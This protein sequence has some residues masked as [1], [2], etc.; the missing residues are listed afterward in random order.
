MSRFVYTFFRYTD[1]EYEKIR[2]LACKFHVIGKEKSQ[3]GNPHLQGYIEFHFPISYPAFKRML[4][5]GAHIEKA[6]KSR[7]PNTI[8]CAKGGD[9]VVLDEGVVI[10]ESSIPKNSQH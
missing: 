7:V 2:Q 1:E 5:P 9:Y 6:R 10:A 8:Y 3:M 4:G